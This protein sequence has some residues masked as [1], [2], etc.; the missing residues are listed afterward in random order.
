[1]TKTKKYFNQDLLCY[2]PL[3]YFFKKNILAN[4]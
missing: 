3:R 1:M 4:V 2:A